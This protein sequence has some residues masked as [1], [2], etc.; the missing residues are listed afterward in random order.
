MAKSEAQDTTRDK[1]KLI[2]K[3]RAMKHDELINNVES[4]MLSC[5]D[6]DCDICSMGQSG[7]MIDDD[8]PP[9]KGRKGAGSEIDT[10]G[11]ASQKIVAS[12][13]GLLQG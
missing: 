12:R 13:S 9:D 3:A 2:A 10:V 6:E 4:H 5:C 7:S 8:S 11:K 1:Y